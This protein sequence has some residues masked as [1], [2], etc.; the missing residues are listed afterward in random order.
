M[1]VKLN[2]SVPA[3]LIWLPDGDTPTADKFGSVNL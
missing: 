1:A 3:A 2:L